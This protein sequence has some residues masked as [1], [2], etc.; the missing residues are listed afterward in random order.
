MDNEKLAALVAAENK[1]VSYQ[2]Q[3]YPQLA[4]M[5]GPLVGKQ[6][7]KGDGTLLA[8]Y[9]ALLPELPSSPSLNVFYVKDN[10]SLRWTVKVSEPVPP[11]GCVYREVSL[12]V[13]S[14][15][16]G[17]LT[18]IADPPQDRSDFTVE[19]ILRKR[20]DVEAADEALRGAKAALCPFGMYDY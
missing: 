14:L 13:G 3:L 5:F 10:F 8:K 15:R 4:A 12:Y 9:K 17:V 1:V 18:E 7:V 2:Q 20:A 6:I 16:D 19:E 11:N